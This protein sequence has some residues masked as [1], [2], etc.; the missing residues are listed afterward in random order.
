MGI[1]LVLALLYSLAWFLAGVGVG[2]AW[3]EDGRRARIR[4]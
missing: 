1:E 3:K 2:I 4:D